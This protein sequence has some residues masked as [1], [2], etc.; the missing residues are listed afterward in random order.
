M[1]IIASVPIWLGRRRAAALGWSC[2]ALLVGGLLVAC[3]QAPPATALPRAVLLVA[4][5]ADA[6][7]QSQSPPAIPLPRAVLLVA[8]RADAP[9]QSQS[10]GVFAQR[11]LTITLE[12]AQVR[13]ASTPDGVGPLCTDDRATL[14]L[15]SAAGAARHWTYQFTSPDR[16]AIVCLPPQTLALPAGAGV[17]TATVTLDDLYPDTYG[18]RAYYLV[19]DTAGGLVAAQDRQPAA[20]RLADPTPIPTRAAPLTTSPITTPVVA[21]AAPPPVP[22]V[23]PGAARRADPGG[24]GALMSDMRVLVV[25]GAAIALVI[26]ALRRWRW[27]RRRVPPAPQLRGVLY[28]FEPATREARTIALPGGAT[29]VA[30][31]RRPLSAVPI[32]DT[33]GAGAAIARIQATARGPVLLEGDA[34]TAPPILLERNQPYAL[35]GGAVTLRY[36]DPGARLERGGSHSRRTADRRS[37]MP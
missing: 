12:A 34:P 36:H 6:A 37:T 8:A 9:H 20:S 24:I 28:L 22:S 31:C 33:G 15:T 13:L 21:T 2:A 18:T 14:T 16:R 11:T 5:R 30:I 10:R 4:A 29:G 27:L 32:S 19:V 25:L 3:V 17:Y 23:V 7:R 26:V 1:R 35:A